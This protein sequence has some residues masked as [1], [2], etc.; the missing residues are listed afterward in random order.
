MKKKFTKLILN[1]MAL[2]IV[3]VQ[4]KETDVNQ[5]STTPIKAKDC[6]YMIYF[7]IT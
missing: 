5:Y 3:K 1:K 4:L 6:Q 7:N 2:T